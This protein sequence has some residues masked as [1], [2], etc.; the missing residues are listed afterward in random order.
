[1][2][3]AN[4]SPDIIENCEKKI[5]SLF[6]I[7]VRWL[8]FIAVHYT[9]HVD[10]VDNFKVKVT[11]YIIISCIYSVAALGLIRQRSDL[12]CFFHYNLDSRRRFN[13]RPQFLPQL[14]FH[15]VR[16]KIRNWDTISSPPCRYSVY[17]YRYTDEYREFRGN[18]KQGLFGFEKCRGIKRVRVRFKTRCICPWPVEPATTPSAYI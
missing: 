18:M 5:P 15:P 12:L 11:F 9:V 10:L 14:F 8:F 3:A 6:R 16:S 4:I 7:A 1:M 13:V 17:R 2:R